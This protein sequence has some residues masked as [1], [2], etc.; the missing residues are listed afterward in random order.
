MNKNSNINNNIK[1]KHQNYKNPKLT[2]RPANPIQLLFSWNPSPIYPSYRV[3]K[4]PGPT[5]FG[6]L[7]WNYNSYAIPYLIH[8]QLRSLSSY[9]ENAEP[10]GQP[11][12]TYSLFWY[13][14]ALSP[15]KKLGN[16]SFS[17][18]EAGGRT[19]QFRVQQEG[20]KIPAASAA[21]TS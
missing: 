13:W 10:R 17:E 8:V 12:E 20:R 2:Q 21:H 9:Q 19:E 6:H 4:Y 7:T 15:A 14:S 1:T 3:G 18:K 16:T 5:A 11:N